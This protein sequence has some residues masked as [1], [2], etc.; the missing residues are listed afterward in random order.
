[1][2]LDALA[3]FNSQRLKLGADLEKWPTIRR[4]HETCHGHPAFVRALP[5]KQPDYRERER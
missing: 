2:T 4:V 1:M 5:E 3:V